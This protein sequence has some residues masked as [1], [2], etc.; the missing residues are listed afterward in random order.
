MNLKELKAIVAGGE[1]EKVE[2]KRSTGELKEAMHTLCAFLNGV[3]GTV[4]F[5]V[6]LD[7]TV[8]G[9]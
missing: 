8:E 6:R 4:L 1:S 9:Q 7:G 2:F 3:G 5:G